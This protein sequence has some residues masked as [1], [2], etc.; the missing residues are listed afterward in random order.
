MIR[1]WST[2]GYLK[3]GDV[4]GRHVVFTTSFVVIVD[5]VLAD[6]VIGSRV[7]DVRLPSSVVYHEH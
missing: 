5:D 2:D 1:Q 4:E 7:L 3:R 6:I